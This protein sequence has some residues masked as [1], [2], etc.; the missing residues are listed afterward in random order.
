[1]LLA[2]VIYETIVDNAKMTFYSMTFYSIQIVSDCMPAFLVI[3]Y[4]VHN[5]IL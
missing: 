1:M 4:K 3:I 5:S 2:T